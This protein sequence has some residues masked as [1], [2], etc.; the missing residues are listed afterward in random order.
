MTCYNING[1]VYMYEI[2]KGHS[3]NVA[4]EISRKSELSD[5]G[6]DANEREF[7]AEKLELELHVSKKQRT[8]RNLFVISIM[9]VLALVV[10]IL[11]PEF[12]GPG[13]ILA[14]IAIGVAVGIVI[15]VLPLIV[16]LLTRHR[17]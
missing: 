10:G 4:N 3:H 7:E 13:G 11:V 2:H 12:M 6:L 16:I 5:L 1:E 9:F 8:L 15:A 14:G 17:N